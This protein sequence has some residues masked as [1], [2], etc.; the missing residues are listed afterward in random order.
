MR[1]GMC[2][3]ALA[4]MLGSAAGAQ[5]PPV[6]SP[7]KPTQPAKPVEPPPDEQEPTIRV[8]VELV[9]LFFSVR[10]KKGAFIANLEKNDFDVLEDGKKQEVR[11]FARE[12]DL[13]LTLGLLVDVSKSQENL[14]DIERDASLAFFTQVIRQKDLAFLIGFGADS[15]LLQDLTNSVPLLERGLKDLRLNAGATGVY[16]PSTFPTPGGP[17]GTVLYDTVWLAAREKM[18]EEVGRKALIILTDGDDVGSRIKIEEAI[19][20]AQRADTIIYPILYED[21]RYT[22]PFFGGVSGEGPMQRLARE[23]GG[24]VF[25]VDRKHSLRNIYDQIQQELRSQY[26]LSYSS[27]NPARDGSFRRI[28]IKTAKKDYKVQARRGY[29]A[30]KD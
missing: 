23:T 8:N 26:A 28:E 5:W 14:I 30:P 29:Y 18:R 9:N 12:T 20:A 10:D 15:E 16:T 6:A 17:R 25:R 7:P 2:G 24:T 22:N 19:E 27:S 3:L 1:R 4:V 13:P 21:P 11:S